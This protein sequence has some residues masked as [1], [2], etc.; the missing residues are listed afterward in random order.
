MVKALIELDDETNQSLNV[1]KAKHGFKDKGM[2][3]SYVVKQFQDEQAPLEFAHLRDGD[4]WMLAEEIPDMDPSFFRIPTHSFVNNFDDPGGRAYAKVMTIYKGYNSVFYYGEKD[5][6]AVAKQLLKKCKDPDF[7]DEVNKQII[8]FADKLRSFCEA[9]PK[10][11][12]EDLSNQ[13]L[14]VFLEGQDAL[15]RDYYRWAWIPQGLDMFHNYFTDY[16]KEYLFSI[17]VSEEQVNEYLVILTQPRSE[18]LIQKQRKE[19]LAIAKEVSDD[20]HNRKV[21]ELLLKRFQEQEAAPLGF[22]T[23][24]KAYEELLEKKVGEIIAE[25]KPF[26]FKKINEYYKTYNYVNRMWIGQPSSFEYFLKELVKLVGNHADIDK[27]IARE[28]QEFEGLQKK[29]TDLF[30]KLGI[31]GKWR[32]A[33]DGFGDFMVTKIYRRYAQLYAC[34]KIN[35]VM[36]EVARRCN[37]S[38][39][40]TRFL[41]PHELKRLLYEGFV[42]KGELSK[43]T[44]FC[45]YYGEKGKEIYFTGVKAKQLADEAAKTNHDLVDEIKGQVACVGNAKGVVKKVFRPSDMHKMNKGDIL[46]SIATDPD[47]VSAMKKAA[48][49]IT[50]QGGVTSHAAIVSREMNTPCVIGTKIATKVLEDGDLV[51]VDARKGLINILERVKK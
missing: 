13:D 36:E 14:W 38:L 30:K 1:I 18:S 49:I 25:I 6:D 27:I 41:L 8:I 44:E 39:K 35:M 28:K 43:R 3:I 23:H 21:F 9:I 15:H 42:D 22:K 17:G 33:F 20:P 16:L 51:E 5:A 24:T 11:N 31:R 32:R 40:Q 34:Y 50:D 47:I 46:V 26:I 19:F 45:V 7:V 48:A 4:P 10:H 29:R 2:T 12:L 37:L